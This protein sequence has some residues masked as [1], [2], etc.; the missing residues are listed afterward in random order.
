MFSVS[1]LIQMREYNTVTWRLKAGIVEKKKT[2]TARPQQHK[3]RP[4]LANGSVN[5]FPLQQNHVTAET[6][7]KITTIILSRVS[8]LDKGFGL[9]TRFIGLLQT[10]STINYSAMANWHFLQ[11]TVA[12]TDSSQ[13]L[14]SVSR[15]NA[16]DLRQHSHSWLQSPRDPWPRFLLSP[17]HVR[18]SKWGLLFD[19]TG[20]GLSI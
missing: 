9:V 19:E 12:R 10:A 7:N 6:D 18:V 2:S 14:L 15:L 5:T 17:R 16:V 4:L 13:C 3:S 8:W 11:F 1:A 20:V